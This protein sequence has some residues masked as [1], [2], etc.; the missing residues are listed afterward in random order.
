MQDGEPNLAGTARTP[1]ARLSPSTAADIGV[2][3]GEPVTV[4]T[5]HG[6]ISLPLAITEMPD[7]VVWLPMNSHGCAVHRDLGVTLGATVQIGRR[8]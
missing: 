3:E 7:N 4:S 8:S 1:V 2:A 6:S 5:D